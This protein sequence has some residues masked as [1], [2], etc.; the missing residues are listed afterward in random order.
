M[1]GYFKNLKSGRFNI[2]VLGFHTQKTI[3]QILKVMHSNTKFPFLRNSGRCRLILSYNYLEQGLTS[4]KLNSF[5]TFS[6]TFCLHGVV[7]CSSNQSFIPGS[8]ILSDVQLVHSIKIYLLGQYGF[9]QLE[10]P[11][12]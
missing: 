2:F 11:L 10:L 5:G 8:T 12:C 3:N 4:M 7:D 1:V 6:L 9:S